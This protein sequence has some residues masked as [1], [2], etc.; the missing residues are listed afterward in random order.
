MAVER[1]TLT[2]FS[3]IGPLGTIH[4]QTI[5]ETPVVLEMFSHTPS[6][7]TPPTT[8]ESA[9]HHHP[10]PEETPIP[11]AEP[12]V[13]Q[14]MIDSSQ[15]INTAEPEAT[16]KTPK[17]R[18]PHPHWSNHDRPP[19]DYSIADD[20]TML[21]LQLVFNITEEHR[22][23]MKKCDDQHADLLKQLATRQSTTRQGTR[24]VAPFTIHP[25]TPKGKGKANQEH[26]Q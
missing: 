8:E 6:D 19:L 1:R 17:T 10:T 25:P 21:V 12:G 11:T 23:E 24:P 15:E 14:E 7:P 18:T 5:N 2:R 26:Q 3:A 22:E 13:N 9:F 20:Q 4:P 16:P